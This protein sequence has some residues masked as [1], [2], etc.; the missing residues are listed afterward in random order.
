MRQ[1]FRCNNITLHP[2]ILGGPIQWTA[3][4]NASRQ[5]AYVHNEVFN[6]T[7]GALTVRTT[8]KYEINVHLTIAGRTIDS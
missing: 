8:G 2:V 7:D 5:Y 1:T 4:V 3:T 6:I